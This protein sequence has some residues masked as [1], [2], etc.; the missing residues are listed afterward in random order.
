MIR[1]SVKP[2]NIFLSAHSLSESCC[3][4]RACAP[5]QFERRR[6]DTP[7][8]LIPVVTQPY[9]SSVTH[10]W[11]AFFTSLIYFASVP[12]FALYGGIFHPARRAAISSSGTSTLIT[13]SCASI[14]IMSPL[15]T[16]AI[17]PPSCASGVTEL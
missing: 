10:P 9:S 15:R 17:G 5:R 11:L 6:C 1:R 16:R 2:G 12:R 4:H 3:L 14:V 13:L 7:P 8:P